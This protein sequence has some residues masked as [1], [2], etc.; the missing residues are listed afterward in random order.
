ME[1]PIEL[2]EVMASPSPYETKTET[3]YAVFNDPAKIDA[4]VALGMPEDLADKLREPLHQTLS[5]S[6]A[7]RYLLWTNENRDKPEWAANLAA[8]GYAILRRQDVTT[9]PWET[10][11]GEELENIDEGRRAYQR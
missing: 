9:T 10:I 5:A 2:A 1:T 8:S 4:Q 6:A 3:W 11:E 7:K